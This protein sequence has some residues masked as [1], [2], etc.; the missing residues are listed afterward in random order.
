MGSNKKQQYFDVIPTKKQPTSQPLRPVTRRSDNGPVLPSRQTRA[1]PPSF[2]KLNQYN[3]G[4]N[5]TYSTSRRP[6]AGKKSH[7]KHKIII[8]LV[9]AL[10]L[11]GAGSLSYGWFMN[12][13]LKRINVLGFTSSVG[14]TENILI[15]GST[16]RCGLKVQ[17]AQWGYC[18]QG[19]TG[20][21]SDIIMVVHL[22]PSTHQVSLLSIPRDTF[23][24]NARAGGESFKIDAALYEG[25]GQLVKAIEEDFG[26]PIQHY[27]ELNFDGF[28]NVVNAA[29][30]IRMDFP[31]PV[32]D[33]Y[34]HLNITKAGCTELNGVTALQLIR[35]RHLQY[36]PASIKTDNTYYWPYEQQSDIG[37]IAR[38]HEFLRVLA[39]SV[40]KRGL[41]NPITDDKLVSSILPNVIVDSGLNDS[42]ILGLIEDFHHANLVNAPQYTMPI[43]VTPFG[44][45]YFEGGNFG[46][47]VFPVEPTDQNIINKFLGSANNLNTMSGKNLPSPSTISVSVMNGSGTP[48]QATIIAND[49]KDLGFSIGEVGNDK[50]VSYQAQ[51]TV[52]YYSNGNEAQ[53][54]TVARQLT[55]YVIMSLNP[56]KVVSGSNVTVV[57]GTDLSVNGAPTASTSASPTTPS[58]SSTQATSTQ[59]TTTNSVTSISPAGGFAAPSQSDAGLTPWDPRACT[60]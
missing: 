45:Y 29:G 16:T 50:P 47:V 32:H 28:V 23:V 14:G 56:K 37:R 22:D 58:A 60:N 18:S 4:T 13:L 48:G 42:N 10:L 52:V 15:A 46:D 54:E 24:P 57:T 40:Q 51:E 12:H 35:A 38:T 53:A 39:S 5:N 6:I 36:K 17:N 43:A 59:T 11:I 3:S 34:S 20:V 44:S 55:G 49:F 19:V 25:P 8:S 26:I 9:V 21:N 2:N 1:I 27:V 33:A 31:L 7:K 30:G 41:S